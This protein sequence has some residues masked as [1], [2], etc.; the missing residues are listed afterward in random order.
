[1]K[2]A[3]SRESPGAGRLTVAERSHLGSL[4][5][6][7]R[8]TAMRRLS[9][10]SEVSTAGWLQLGRPSQQ[11]ELSSPTQGAALSPDPGLWSEPRLEAEVVTLWSLWMFWQR[12]N[13]LLARASPFPKSPSSCYSSPPHPREPYPLSLRQ[14]NGDSPSTKATGWKPQRAACSSPSCPCWPP[15]SDLSSESLPQPALPISPGLAWIKMLL[16]PRG[17]LRVGEATLW[18]VCWTCP[19]VSVLWGWGW[20]WGL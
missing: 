9:V 8:N 12:G 14:D 5:A 2:D 16:P 18:W 15:G 1:M 20:G 17:L 13:L 3:G 19:A 4:L 6:I 7:L 11:Q 10:W